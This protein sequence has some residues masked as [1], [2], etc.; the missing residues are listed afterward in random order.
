MTVEVSY[1]GAV[2]LCEAGAGVVVDSGW[3]DRQGKFVEGSQDP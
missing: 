3:S 1:E 2:A